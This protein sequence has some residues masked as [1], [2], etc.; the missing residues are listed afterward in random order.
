MSW[1]KSE[2]YLILIEGRSGLVGPQLG[3]EPQGAVLR[4]VGRGCGVGGVVSLAH[5]LSHLVSLGR[6]TDQHALA[7]G[8]F[9]LDEIGGNLRICDDNESQLSGYFLSVI[10]VDCSFNCHL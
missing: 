4:D 10:V 6:R 8:H 5:I 7:S 1:S 3:G 2:S 9:H